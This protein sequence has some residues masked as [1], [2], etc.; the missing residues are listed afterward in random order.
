MNGFSTGQLPVLVRHIKL[1][2]IVLIPIDMHR[3]KTW[4]RI[5]SA[6]MTKVIETPILCC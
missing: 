1:R 4:L 2:P 3:P 5:L 6:V